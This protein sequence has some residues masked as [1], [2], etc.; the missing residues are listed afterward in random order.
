MVEQRWLDVAKVDALLVDRR[1][2]RSI[3]AF[4]QAAVE[5][6]PCRWPTVPPMHRLLSWMARG[7]AG[8]VTSGVFRRFEVV[9][10]ADHAGP[11]LIV[12]N[13]FNGFVDAVVSMWHFS[14]DMP[15]EPTCA[16]WLL[17]AAPP[18][19]ALLSGLL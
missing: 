7:V 2:I 19:P 13:H 8:F 1:R 15:L 10:S 3:A 18:A 12:A 4:S 9:G 6:A 16:P 17:A 5:A 11:R 14:Q